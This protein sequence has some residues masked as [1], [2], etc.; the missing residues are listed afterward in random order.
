MRAPSRWDELL[1]EWAVDGEMDLGG[2]GL[3]VNGRTTIERLGA[4]IVVRTTL[5]PAEF[6][7]SLSIIGGGE[8]GDPEPMH[9]FDERG[10]QRLYLTTIA[11]DTWTIWTGDETWRESPGFRQRY[12]GQL[13]PGS[14]RI[15]GAWQRGLDDSG[16]RWELDFRFDYAR[17]R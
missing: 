10:V 2:R 1:G 16:E 8:A 12:V 4:F 9:Y 5:E 6:P 11:G 3:A 13:A 15:S 14:D 17:L 7:D